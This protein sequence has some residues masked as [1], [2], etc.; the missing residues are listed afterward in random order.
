MP[1]GHEA[2]SL[3]SN[4]RLG[5]CRYAWKTHICIHTLP[6]DRDNHMVGGGWPHQLKFYPTRA[7]T[8]STVPWKSWSCSCEMG[9]VGHLRSWQVI[10][11]AH[12]CLVHIRWREKSSNNHHIVNNAITCT[13]HKDR[14]T[15]SGRTSAA[16]ASSDPSSLESVLFVSSNSASEGPKVRTCC[17]RVCL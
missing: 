13:R 14:C 7:R 17:A 15:S 10:L 16:R 2:K 12:A 8:F 3:V 11:Q 1:S 6:N 5:S 9:G 4:N